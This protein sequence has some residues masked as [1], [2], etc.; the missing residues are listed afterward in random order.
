MGEEQKKGRRRWKRWAIP[1]AVVL[2]AVALF[3]GARQT[4]LVKDAIVAVLDFCK[5]LGFWAAPVIALAYVVACVFMFPGSLLTV[6]S[7]FVF[8]AI[9]GSALWG[10]VAGTATVSIS[11]TLGACTAF[12]VGRWIARDWVRRKVAGDPRFAAIDRAVGEHGFKIV[13][14]TRLTVVFPF[15]LQN[16]VYGLTDVSFWN[17]AI[18]SL[19]GMLPGTVAFVYLGA[20]A[21]SLT[22]IAAGEATGGPTKWIVIGVGLVFAFAAATY[23]GRVARRALQEAAEEAGAEELAE[24]TAPS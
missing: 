11:S 3:V 1:V 5:G 21:Q 2:A 22:A 18:G 12:S 15:V 14:L 13:V 23:V 19:I 20:V 24:G 9:T 8:A 16:Y 4:T 17:H 6:G 7:G 10:V